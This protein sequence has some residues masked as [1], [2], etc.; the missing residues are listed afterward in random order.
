MGQQVVIWVWGGFSVKFPT[1]TRFYSLHY[2]LPFL[3]I[4]LVLVHLVFLHET[5]S[6]HPL[7]ALAEDKVT[8]FPYFI[9]KDVFGFLARFLF[10]KELFFLYPQ[11]FDEP[12]NY[13]EA[14]PLATPSHILP[15][16]Y[17]LSAYAVLRAIP[18]KLGGVL[19]LVGFVFLL[20][21]LPF[22]AQKPKSYN[23]ASSVLF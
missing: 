18:K 16:W 17:F 19:G 10:V 14:N 2:L 21:I 12:Q 4:V 15:E 8:F 6:N 9:S 3:I 22:L 11:L 20:Y 13:I 23:I 5:G 7:G 1:L